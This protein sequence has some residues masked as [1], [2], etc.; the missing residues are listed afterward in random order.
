M[1]SMYPPS[2]RTDY[3]QH[4]FRPYPPPVPCVPCGPLCP[5]KFAKKLR[6]LGYPKFADIARI[7]GLTNLDDRDLTVFA[8]P[9]EQLPDDFIQSCNRLK[10][11]NIIKSSTVERLIPIEVFAQSENG[12]YRTLNRSHQLHIVFSEGKMFVDGRP[13]EKG[14]V[15]DAPSGNIMVHQIGAPINPLMTM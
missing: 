12:F 6:C 13:V 8:V 9:D 2:M 11:L 7:S 3:N 4:P 5:S 10:A 1:V 15:R 14:N